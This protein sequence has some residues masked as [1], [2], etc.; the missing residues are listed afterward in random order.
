MAKSSGQR[1]VKPLVVER[2]EFECILLEYKYDGFSLLFFCRSSGY[3]YSFC[4]SVFVLRTTRFTISVTSRHV[5]SPPAAPI[6]FSPSLNFIVCIKAPTDRHHRAVVVGVVCAVISSKPKLYTIS[7]SGAGGG[8][9]EN[10]VEKTRVGPEEK[11]AFER[12]TATAACPGKMAT[13]NN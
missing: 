3:L 7:S 9:W 13:G 10:R 11:I 5:F 1:R 4:F 2:H 8:E 6:E 12:Y